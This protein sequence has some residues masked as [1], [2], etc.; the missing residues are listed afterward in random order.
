MG[1]YE[2]VG[3]PPAGYEQ[4]Y[5]AGF[6]MVRVL[7]AELCSDTV[8]LTVTSS[9]AAAAGS[10]QRHRTRIAMGMMCFMADPSVII[11]EWQG[12]LKRVQE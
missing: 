12:R 2:Q 7:F 1:V 6:A 8:P 11:R 5:R 10:T 3:V 4:P 9:I